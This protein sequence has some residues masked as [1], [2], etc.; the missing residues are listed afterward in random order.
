MARPKKVVQEI[1][2]NMPTAQVEE[3]KVID[4]K[5]KKE[6]IIQVVI[7][8]AKQLAKEKINKLMVEESRL[9]KGRFR[10]FE[11]PGAPQRIIVRKYLGIPVFDKIMED[12]KMYE[13]PLYVARHLNGIDV[14]AKACGGKIHTCAWPTHSFQWENDKPMPG[15][16]MD[17]QGIPVPI[18]GVQK[19]NRRYGFESLE[20]DTEG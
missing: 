12:Q 15:S 10:N 14:S 13:I 8:T 18:I 2:E 11:S 16:R 5:D 1:K 6:E 3:I 17:D 19:W 20:F 9:V 7:P 4:S